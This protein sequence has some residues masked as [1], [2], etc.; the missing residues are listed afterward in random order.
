M[1]NAKPISRTRNTTLMTWD[2]R[3]WRLRCLSGLENLL[4]PMS[5]VLRRRVSLG[6]IQKQFG[7][8]PDL[9]KV[10]QRVVAQRTKAEDDSLKLTPSKGLSLKPLSLVQKTPAPSSRGCS[11]M[12]SWIVGHSPRRLQVGCRS[13]MGR[14][15][16]RSLKTHWMRS[17]A[18]VPVPAMPDSEW[19]AHRT[20]LCRGS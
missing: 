2:R 18:H 3:K 17:T 8:M 19:N 1:Q 11:L 13:R 7:V 15:S 4:P 10:T 16:N 9:N 5:N 6:G 20:R 14:Q 12:G